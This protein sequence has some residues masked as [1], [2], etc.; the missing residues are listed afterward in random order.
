[1]NYS[2][3]MVILFIVRGLDSSCSGEATKVVQEYGTEFRRR[4]PSPVC[5]PKLQY[6]FWV[7]GINCEQR[8][9]WST[10]RILSFW[11][12][13]SVLPLFGFPDSC[14]TTMHCTFVVPP[15]DG[16]A[17]ISIIDTVRYAIGD[18][19]FFVLCD[20]LSTATIRTSA[21]GTSTVLCRML[22]LCWVMILKICQFYYAV[23][24]AA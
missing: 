16:T 8:V 19:P 21:G 11:T 12:K 15:H 4:I 2:T 13:S 6:S 14:R 18:Y 10:F 1:M 22:K 20:K 3:T 17:D 5:L 9:F 7:F 23:F 24:A